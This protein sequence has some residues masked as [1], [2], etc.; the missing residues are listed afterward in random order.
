VA[1]LDHIARDVGIDL[2][3]G[4]GDLP[5]TALLENPQ[6]GLW[7]ASIAFKSR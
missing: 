7:R 4:V 5:A 3:D 2:A 1:G 6:P